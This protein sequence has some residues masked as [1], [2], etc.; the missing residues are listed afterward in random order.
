MSSGRSG[1][2]ME[3]LFSGRL[4][5]GLEDDVTWRLIAHEQPKKTHVA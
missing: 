1:S 4:V 3:M 2:K 5:S